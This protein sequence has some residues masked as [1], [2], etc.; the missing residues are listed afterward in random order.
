MAA[1]KDDVNVERSSDHKKPS[2]E[3]QA[4][5]GTTVHETEQKSFDESEICGAPAAPVGASTGLNTKWIAAGAAAGAGVLLCA[6]S[7]RRWQESTSQFID[8]VI[9]CQ[10][11]VVYPISHRILS[12]VITCRNQS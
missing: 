4:S 3:T 2:A 10:L 8:A 5:H 11:L 9:K 12:W 1:R 7:V 6:A